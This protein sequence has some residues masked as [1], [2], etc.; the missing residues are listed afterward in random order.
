MDTVLSLQFLNGV[1]ISFSDF[2]VIY[3][4]SL[5]KKNLKRRTRFKYIVLTK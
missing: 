4:V 3:S 1:L 2:Y 5:E